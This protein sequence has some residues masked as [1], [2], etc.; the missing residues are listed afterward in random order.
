VLSSG[1]RRRPEVRLGVAYFRSAAI[2]VS[3]NTCTSCSG[4]EEGVSNPTQHLSY[5]TSG[6]R[7]KLVVIRC[8]G[9]N[10]GTGYLSKARV[11]R[12]PSRHACVL[13][14]LEHTTST[15]MC[16]YTPPRPPRP[17]PPIYTPLPCVPRAS[18]RTPAR[19]PPLRLR[20]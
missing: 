7:T 11:W 12:E 10:L 8:G 4:H 16:A 15:F 20:A 14:S 2:A 9:Y 5:F 1:H 18:S 13:S 6:P 3:N 19:A 17:P